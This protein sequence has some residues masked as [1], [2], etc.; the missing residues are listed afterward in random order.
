MVAHYGPFAE[1]G[2]NFVLLLCAKGGVLLAI[3]YVV[4]ALLRRGSA[5]MRAL[6]WAAALIA[7]LVLPAVVAIARVAPPA[8]VLGIGQPVRVLAS[9]EGR[10]SR[11]PQPAQPLQVSGTRP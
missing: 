8:A 11:V 4:V 3:A 5:A 9:G 2:L 6:V 1:A 7:L 10:S